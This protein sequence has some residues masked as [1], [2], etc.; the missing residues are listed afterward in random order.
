MTT[1]AR[2][3]LISWGVATLIALIRLRT[4]EQWADL[5]V[6]N[7]RI[8]GFVKIARG[9]GFDLHA[10]VEGLAMLVLGQRPAAPAARAIEDVASTLLI[11]TPNGPC[12]QAVVAA[13]ADEVA[14]RSADENERRIA[15]EVR[16]FAD[17]LIK[18]A[19]GP[20]DST[21][22]SGSADATPGTVAMSDAQA[23]PA[24]SGVS[25]VTAYMTVSSNQSPGQIAR[26]VVDI[27]AEK[28]RNPTGSRAFMAPLE[29]AD[30]TPAES[31]ANAAPL[32]SASKP[33]PGHEVAPLPSA[34][35]TGSL[36]DCTSPIAPVVPELVADAPPPLAATLPTLPAVLAP[37][38]IPPTP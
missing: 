18:I 19:G 16:S 26:R 6:T 2:A 20:N 1:E 29:R 14:R 12:F 9:A 36:A 23:E 4:P 38:A 17:T 28:A 32:A 30:E 5:A 7:P 27:L 34:P 15:A 24:K 11:A 31:P 22:T 13:S 25:N 37:G 10:V 3:I 8:A 21:I 33:Y 35:G